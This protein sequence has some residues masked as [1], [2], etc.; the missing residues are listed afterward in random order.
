MAN[1]RAARKRVR[2]NATKNAANRQFRTML[3]ST[4]KDFLQAKDKSAEKLNSAVSLVHRVASKGIIHKNRAASIVSK[5]HK[6]S[7]TK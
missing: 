6:S 4:V 5:L 3:R 7:A 2:Q 1:S